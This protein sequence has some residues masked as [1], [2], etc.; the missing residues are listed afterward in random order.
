M[1]AADDAWPAPAKINLFLHVT[2]R[3]ADGYHRLQTVFQFLDYGDRLHFT[4]RTD[5]RIRRCSELAGVAPDDDLAVRAARLLQTETGCRL[6]AD[7][8]VEKRL[9][10]GGGL[11]GGSSN[12]ATT[13]VALNALWRLGLNEDRLAELGL[14][15]GAD[16]PV[17]V[18]GR[19]AWGEG[20]GEQL[21]AVELPQPWFLVVT[22]PVSIATAAV[23]QAPELTRDCPPITIRDFLA[24]AGGNVC[25]PV[26]RT[27]YPAVAE[28]L[29]WLE[30]FSKA[31]LSGTG[32]SVFAAFARQD[33][34]LRAAEQ[35][36][37]GWQKIVARGRN[38]SALLERLT[39]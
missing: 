16:V 13:L 28:A 27:R 36:P 30:G 8:D 31:R 32:S 29:D 3:R 33:D 7:I 20:V 11:G 25:E 17:F 21:Q 15:L 14:R 22:P 18:R 24:G 35:A 38:R 5:G 26:V 19:A 39:R 9:P 12:A 1:P 2:G 6:G 10:L 34:A 23:F 4:V 37:A